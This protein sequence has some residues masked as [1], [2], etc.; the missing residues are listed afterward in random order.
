MLESC[1]GPAGVLLMSCYESDRVMLGSRWCCHG[2]ASKCPADWT[3]LVP[4]N[5]EEESTFKRIED[6]SVVLKEAEET[7]I[8]KCFDRIILQPKL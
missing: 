6:L 1:W 3:V 7:Q 5:E 2:P 8:L 4:N